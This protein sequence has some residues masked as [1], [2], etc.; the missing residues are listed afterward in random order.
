[1]HREKGNSTVVV[2]YLA[3][4][5]P[6]IFDPIIQASLSCDLSLLSCYTT[7]DLFSGLLGFLWVFPMSRASVIGVLC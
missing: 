7:G 1:M 2:Q 6:L 4:I 3:Y 5:S